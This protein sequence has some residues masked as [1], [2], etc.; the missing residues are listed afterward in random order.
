MNDNLPVITRE[1]DEKE[2]KTNWRATMAPPDMETTTQRN[3]LPKKKWVQKGLWGK[4]VEGNTTKETK[5]CKVKDYVKKDNTPV[6]GHDRNIRANPSAEKRVKT[7]RSNKTGKRAK[8]CVYPKDPKDDKNSV[9]LATSLHIQE[10]RNM[11][12]NKY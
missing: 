5:T 7:K 10:L 12:R 4:H 3:Q 6:K 2:T 1:E 9:Q 8:H 11:C